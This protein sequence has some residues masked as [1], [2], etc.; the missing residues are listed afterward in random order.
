MA[1]ELKDIMVKEMVSRYRNANNY[2]FVGY[3]GTSAIEFNRLKR[4]LYQKEV[5]LEVVKNSLAAIA[6]K[7]LGNTEVLD[8]FEGPTAVVVGGNDPVTM[9]KELVGWSK[10]IEYLKF[11][12]GVV[13]GEFV[14]AEDIGR[15]AELPSLPV[16][17][18]QIVRCV[19]APITGVV[20]AFNAVLRSLVTV[21]QAVKNEKE[22]GS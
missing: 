14:T 19:N 16:L 10:K 21:L 2:M 17:R 12:G 11:R 7:E 5:S 18:T 15:L 22:K 20:S 4:D 1:S 13:D 8:F 9:A 6:F 3:Q